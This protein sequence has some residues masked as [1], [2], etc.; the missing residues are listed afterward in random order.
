MIC[1]ESSDTKRPK[2]S[3]CCNYMEGESKIFDSLAISGGSKS[4]SYL[5]SMM[6]RGRDWIAMLFS[7]INYI[8]LRGVVLRT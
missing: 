8:S 6:L 3:V 4:V 1:E 5:T 2:S 7:M